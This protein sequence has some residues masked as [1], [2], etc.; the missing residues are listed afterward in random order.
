MVQ[1]ITAP[2]QLRCIGK[3]EKEIAL[4]EFGCCLYYSKH[5]ASENRKKY[6]R[7]LAPLQIRGTK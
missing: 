5:I 1:M 3:K 2:L 6:V 4:V 7:F